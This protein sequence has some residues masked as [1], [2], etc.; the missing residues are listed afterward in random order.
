METF[1]IS[2]LTIITII[3]KIVVNTVIRMMMIIGDKILTMLTIIPIVAS[4]MTIF[5]CR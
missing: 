3:V 1:G 4:F 5:L 2:F